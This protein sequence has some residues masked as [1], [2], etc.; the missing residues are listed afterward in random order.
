MSTKPFADFGDFEDLEEQAP[1]HGTSF[2]H[3]DADALLGLQLGIP[4]VN[5][6]NAAEED[7]ETHQ[8]VLVTPKGEQCRAF[9][10][11]GVTFCVRAN[12]KRHVKA[13]KLELPGETVFIR[14]TSTSAF[15]EPSCLVD[16]LAPDEFGTWLTLTLTSAQWAERFMATTMAAAVDGPIQEQE[17]L[18]AEAKNLQTPAPKRKRSA[19]D[20]ESKK[21]M[22]R[23]STYLPKCQDSVSSTDLSQL[24][25]APR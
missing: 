2:D 11:S 14:K 10:Q 18:L 21:V 3:V 24:T 25:S 22:K 23:H 12:C 5:M 17:E 1:P 6:E 15:L 7:K 13:D 16:Q 20:E 8:I 9:L 19:Q 4:D